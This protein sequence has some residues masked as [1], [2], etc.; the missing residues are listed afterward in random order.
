[1]ADDDDGRAAAVERSCGRAASSPCR[2][3]RSTG[4]PSH[5]TRRR[6]RAPVPGQAAAARQGDRVASRDAAQA[7]S[8]GVM[9]PAAAA[10]TAACWPGGLTVIVPQRPDVALPAGLTGGDADDRA[11]RP[12]PSEP[13][14]SSPGRRP[15]ADHLGQRLRPARGPRRAGDPRPARGRRGPDPRRGAARGGPP[16]TVVDCTGDRPLVLRD[17][18]IPVARL[19]A[20]LDAAGIAHDLVGG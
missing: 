4:S 18:A 6:H 17:G 10:L 11:A 2:P 16:S 15:A 14:A 8:I 5:S 7:E 9:G 19:V 13:R 12:G 3:T 20:I 1:M